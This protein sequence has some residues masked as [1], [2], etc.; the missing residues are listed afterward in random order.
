[1]RRILAL[2]TAAVIAYILWGEPPRKAINRLSGLFGLSPSIAVVYPGDATGEPFLAGIRLALEEINASGG[3]KGHQVKLLAIREDSF[4]DPPGSD[5][6]QSALDLAERLADDPNV[7]AIIGHGS[8]DA[9]IPAVQVYE[10]EKKLYLATY[11]T[12]VTL[13][14]AF[15]RHLFTLLPDNSVSSEVLAQYAADNGYRNIV[16]L[17]GTSDYARESAIFFAQSSFTRGLK[18]LHRINIDFTRRSVHQI[19]LDLLDNPRL[20]ASSID[21]IML[22]SSGDE[23]GQIIRQAR[24]L[25]I[26]VPILG[27]DNMDDPQIVNVAGAAMEGTVAINVADMLAASRLPNH[28]TFFS[29]YRK[30]TG[31]EPITIAA[32]AY[33]SVHLVKRAA[34]HADS[35]SGEDLA[36]SLHL[37]HHF[38]P[39]FEGVGSRYA[40]DRL[41]R[42]MDRDI[43]VLRHDGKAFQRVRA[44]RNNGSGRVSVSP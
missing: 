19:M 10:R 3:L 37:A 7:I 35:L 17:A 15:K 25:G 21:A 27:L 16:I 26:T 14:S 34:E 24:L 6:V 4:A 18:I 28:Q 8:S 22:V 5:G 43:Y 1:M 36:D 38:A 39:P 11:A 9:A 29:E 30:R 33:D 44:Y 42:A 41:G 31:K 40:F 32:L 20:P 13:A 23:I 2:L 12:N